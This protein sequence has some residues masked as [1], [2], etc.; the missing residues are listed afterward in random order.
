MVT[1]FPSEPVVG[2]LW[3]DHADANWAPCAA[4]AARS[5]EGDAIRTIKSATSVICFTIIDTSV[6]LTTDERV[7][8]SASRTSMLAEKRQHRS[9]ED[10]RLLHTPS[11]PLLHDD[12]FEP[13]MRAAKGEAPQEGHTGPRRRS[14]GV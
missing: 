13:L 10:F 3:W 2:L 1:A 6:H 11:D 5:D 8:V 14:A 12:G 7:R 9:V 4:S